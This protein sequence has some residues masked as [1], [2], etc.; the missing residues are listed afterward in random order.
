MIAQ[1]SLEEVTHR[2]LSLEERVALLS[3]RLPV[4]E[5]ISEEHT[6]EYVIFVN[7]KETWSGQELEGSYLD[8]RD[9][10]PNADVMISWRLQPSVT[11]V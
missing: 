5:K 7:G 1:L 4:P 6:I 10:Y 8:I 11:L 9:R 2:L 3:T